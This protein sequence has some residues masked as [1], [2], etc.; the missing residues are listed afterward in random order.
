MGIPSDLQPRAPAASTPQHPD[1]LPVP[2]KDKPAA[3]ASD[4]LGGVATTQAVK[5]QAMGPLTPRGVL[6][7]AYDQMAQQ[8]GLSPMARAEFVRRAAA[9]DDGQLHAA[10]QDPLATGPALK[11]AALDDAM[12]GGVVAVAPTLAQVG[13]LHVLKAQDASNTGFGNS[14]FGFNAFN[15]IG[16]GTPWLAPQG[17]TLPVTPGNTAVTP[18]IAAKLLENISRGEPPFRPELGQ[19]GGVSWFVTGGA[20]HTGTGTDKSVS[21]PVEVTNTSGKPPLQFGER[22]LLE[23][24]ASKYTAAEQ[25]AEAQVRQSSGRTNGEPLN[26]SQ[27]GQVRYQAHRIAER[28]MWTEVGDRVRNSESGIGKVDLKDSKFSRSSDGEFTL[29]SKAENVRIKGGAQALADII[30]TQGVKAEP[31]VLEAAEKLASNEKWA[32]RVQGAFRV[33]GKVLIVVGL[34]NDAYRIYTAKDKVKTTVEAA[35][36]WAGATAAGGAFA[37]W[38]APAD[39]AGPWAWAAHG[40][41]TLVAGGVGYWAGSEVT[42]KLYELT[43]EGKPIDVAR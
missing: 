2:A 9:L 35:G 39:A 28:A 27:R 25:T 26:S 14:S 10:S 11:G 18:E 36:G 21:V 24:Y 12:R 41:G 16:A 20:P 15:G 34:A 32:G 8:A 1:L 40:V 37:T 7:K 43:I 5:V 4:D 3:P 6:D 23:I 19:V 33:G 29:T 22:E 17:P 42:K 31:G 38:F 13:L 30:R